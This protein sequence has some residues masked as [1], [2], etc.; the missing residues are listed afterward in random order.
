MLIYRNV[1]KLLGDVLVGDKEVN[2]V[3]YREAVPFKYSGKL[4]AQTILTSVWHA[5]SIPSGDLPFKQLNTLEDLE[6]FLQSTDK[7]VL[8]FDICG[9]VPKIS[10]ADNKNTRFSTTTKTNHANLNQGKNCAL[11]KK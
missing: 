1:E 11:T 9:W 6:F 2:L 3:L 4:S 7:A 10:A 8:L 5:M